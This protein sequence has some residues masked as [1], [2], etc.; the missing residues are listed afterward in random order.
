MTLALAILGAVGAIATILTLYSRY[1]PPK[2]V[3]EKV[4]DSVQS[5]REETDAF[6]KSGRPS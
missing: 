4:E 6:K 1:F 2:T 5:V 3:E